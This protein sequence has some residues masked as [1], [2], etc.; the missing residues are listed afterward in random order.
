MKSRQGKIYKEI[1]G[2]KKIPRTVEGIW[3]TVMRARKLKKDTVKAKKYGSSV[4]LSRGNIFD[5][6]SYPDDIDSRL[7]SNK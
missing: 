4:T 1:T 7:G 6:K 2:S 5:L 3:N